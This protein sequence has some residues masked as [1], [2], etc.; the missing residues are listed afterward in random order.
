LLIGCRLRR[1]ELVGLKRQDFQIREEHWVVADLIGKGKHIRT[2]PVP[3]WAKHAAD[4]WISAAAICNGPVF[5]R[6]NRLGKV[7]GEGI[8]PQ[9]ICHIVNAAAVNARIENLAPHDLRRIRHKEEHLREAAP[10]LR[11]GNWSRFS[12]CS[13][14]HP[15]RLPSD[16]PGRNKIW[17][18]P[19]DG[20]RLR[21]AI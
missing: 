7:W 12:C 19:N 9:A 18:T 11:V 20:I 1:A 16:I 5:R 6:M 2:A 15:C 8:T 10:G 4:D 17:C 3:A 13:G 14:M 21:V